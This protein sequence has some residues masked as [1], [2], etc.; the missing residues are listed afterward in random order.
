MRAMAESL[1]DILGVAKTA[2]ADE[3][4][5]AYRKLAREHHPD[6]NPGNSAAEEKFKKVSAA[7]EVLSDDKKRAAYDEFGDASLQGG[8]DPDKARDVPALADTRSS[9]ATSRFHDDDEGPAEFDFS[10]LFGRGARSAARRRSARDARR[11]T[12]ARRSRA[13]RSRLDL[14]GPGARTRPHSAGRRQRLDRSAS[15]ARARPVRA[16]ARPA[17]S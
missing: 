10:E 2:T 9:S 4:R 5:K 11:S 13:P 7:Y 14:P 1:Y 16:A 17:I 3:I 12:S 8:F 6:V 15:P